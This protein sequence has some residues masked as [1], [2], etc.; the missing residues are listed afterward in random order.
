MRL[1]MKNGMMCNITIEGAGQLSVE[2]VKSFF[3]SININISDDFAEFYSEFNG[4]CGFPEIHSTE[5]DSFSIEDIFYIDVFTPDELVKSNDDEVKKLIDNIFF[6]ASDGGE[7]EF[8][9]DY[10]Q[11]KYFWISYID[12]GEELPE[13]LGDNKDEFINYLIDYFADAD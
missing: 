9:Y 2:Q 6:F 12:I 10:I 8:G 4:G 1:I 3:K 5:D 7:M 11:N 13:Y